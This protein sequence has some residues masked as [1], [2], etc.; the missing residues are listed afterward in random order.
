M[1]TPKPCSPLA[2]IDFPAFEDDLP[3]TGFT[4]DEAFLE[5]CGSQSDRK[6]SLSSNNM[7]IIS[8][9]QLLASVL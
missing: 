9:N 5:P 2:Q 4:D 8:V 1:D 7:D 6:S 3:I